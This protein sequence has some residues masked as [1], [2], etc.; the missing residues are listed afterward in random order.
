MRALVDDFALATEGLLLGGG[1]TAL[2]GYYS[3]FGGDK[4]WKKHQ[5]EFETLFT[6]GKV[7]VSTPKLGAM[8]K[9]LSSYTKSEETI[10]IPTSVQ[11]QSCQ[12]DG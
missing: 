5:R 2:G 11:P 12:T 6:R 10:F 1:L 7:T 3:I 9:T 4:H 8:L